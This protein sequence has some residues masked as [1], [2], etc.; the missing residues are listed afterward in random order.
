MSDARERLIRDGDESLRFLEQPSY[1]AHTTDGQI[2]GMLRTAL[3]SPR[4]GHDRSYRERTDR[5]YA[6]YYDRGAP[7][8]EAKPALDVLHLTEG[9]RRALEAGD[10]SLAALE[11]PFV[12]DKPAEIG[13]MLRTALNSP[14]S[15]RDPAYRARVDAAYD[16]HYDDVRAD[17]DKDYLRALAGSA[18]HA[19]SE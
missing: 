13:E 16:R 11:R 14:R 8:E 15:D 6:A 1:P 18:G 12:F 19:D 10:K 5:L 7:K 9:Q 2:E 17:R 3:A 4:Y